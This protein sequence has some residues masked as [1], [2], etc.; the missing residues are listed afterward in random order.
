MAEELVPI[1]YVRNGIKAV[2]WYARLGFMI[3]GEYRFAPGCRNMCVFVAVKLRS[4][5]LNI[6]MMRDRTRSCISM[7][8]ILIKLRPSSTS[9]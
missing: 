3:E 6:R 1:F 8:M 5:C 9:T 7:L 4:I 2:R